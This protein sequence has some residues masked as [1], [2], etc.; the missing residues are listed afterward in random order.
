[1]QEVRKGKKQGKRKEGSGRRRE[2]EKEIQGRWISRRKRKETGR[3]VWMQAEI[4]RELK[5]G[6]RAGVSR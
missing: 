1:M 2:K 3:E 4:I 6:E 5:K